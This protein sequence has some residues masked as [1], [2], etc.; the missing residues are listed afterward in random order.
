MK[1]NPYLK[2]TQK[3]TE[4]GLGAWQLGINSGWKG[5]SDREA[6]SLV[7][8]ALDLGIN[9]GPIGPKRSCRSYSI[10]CFDR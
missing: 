5:L 6:I 8:G 7:H 2:A 4:I 10:G 1:L 9:D 3:V